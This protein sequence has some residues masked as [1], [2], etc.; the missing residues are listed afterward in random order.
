MRIVEFSDCDGDPCRN[1]GTCVAKGKGFVCACPVGHSG[2]YCEGTGNICL[3]H[4]APLLYIV[5]AKSP[6]FLL[7]INP[8]ILVLLQVC[9]VQAIHN[10]YNF[11]CCTLLA[12]PKL[13]LVTLS[14]LFHFVLH[15]SPL[16]K[17]ANCIPLITIEYHS[18]SMICRQDS[19]IF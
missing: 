11:M 7:S 16:Q 2:V 15:Y 14:I 18:L 6:Y 12:K 1:G 9:T 8:N 17:R 3:V 5:L 10:I 19:V 4:H 13:S